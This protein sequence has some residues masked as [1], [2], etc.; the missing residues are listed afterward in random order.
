[1]LNHA[2]D[3]K[4][5][6]NGFTKIFIKKDIHPIVRKE[7]NRMKSAE[8]N[9]KRKPENVARTVK[10]DPE[11]RCLSVD[12][13]VVD[14]FRMCF[15]LDNGMM[16]QLSMIILNINGAAS[17]MEERRCI[18]LLT[19]YDIICLSEIKCDYPFS[20]PGYRCI[21]SRIIPGEEKRGG[22]AVLFKECIWNSVHDI[23]TVKDQ[24]WFY[25]TLFPEFQF[26]AVY[27]APR[28]SL[29]FSME[30][31]A[32]MSDQ[33]MSTERHV[34]IVGDINAR[35]PSLDIFSSQEKG[36]KHTQNPDTRGTRTA[37]T[38]LHCVI[39]VI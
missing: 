11:T 21:R 23:F 34:M 37:K 38:W 31:F 22:V 29:F 30:S 9:E 18:E 33:V 6:G 26:G 16:S 8:Y 7:L 28:D 1:M 20:M 14:R 27:I 10:Y 12:G 15:F 35:M 4:N 13:I 25:V 24:V 39:C 36:I 5:A 17:K 2:K 19:Q 32:F 3:L